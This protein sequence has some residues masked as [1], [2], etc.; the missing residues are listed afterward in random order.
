MNIRDISI[1]HRG[2]SLVEALLSVALFAL[3]VTAL[4]GAVIYG[5]ESTAVAGARARAIGI[6]E[7]GLEASRNIRDNNFGE[8]TDGNHG[9]T[10]SAN[11][12]F[13]SGTSDT[14]DSFTRQVAISTPSTDRRQTVSTVTWQQTPSRTGSVAL[15]T[16]HTNWRASSG[17]GASTCL[18]FCT[19]IGY[20][21]ATCRPAATTCEAHRE[22]HEAVG[23]PICAATSPG[24][25]LC[26]C[27]P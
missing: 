12:W 8:L 15:T 16:Y 5:R 22:V 4:V 3:L 23:D 25:A 1:A 24:T 7:E 2:F 14:V 18:E 10:I 26:C 6:A 20:T 17:G 9:L 11:Q 21:D 19:S 27:K 13:F